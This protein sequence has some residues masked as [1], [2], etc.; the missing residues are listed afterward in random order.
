[1]DQIQSLRGINLKC[2]RLLFA[3]VQNCIA[4]SRIANCCPE[5]YHNT[6]I[7]RPIDS[8]CLLK[9][10]SPRVSNLRPPVY[11]TVSAR[12]MQTPLE[13]RRVTQFPECNSLVL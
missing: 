2:V 8:I 11:L 6:T 9:L 7:G 1:M 5:L 12:L 3:V 4:H 10:L 13:Q